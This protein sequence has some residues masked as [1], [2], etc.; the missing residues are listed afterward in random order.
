[1]MHVLEQFSKLFDKKQKRS[2]IF[3][4]MLMVLGAF[5][6]T[7]GI[8]LIVPLVAVVLDEKFFQ[9]NTVVKNISALLGIESVKVFVIYML[10][11]LILIFII[12]DLFLFFEYYI[13]QKFVCS[14]RVRVQKQLMESFLQRPYEFFLNESTGNIQRS[15][16]DDVNRSFM[17]LNNVMTLFTEL[18]VCIAVLCAVIAVDTV[19]AIFV[20]IVLLAEVLLILTK[21]KPAMTRLGN[22]VREVSA[23]INKWI[24]QSVQGIKEIKVT[25][26]QG[27][28]VQ[29]YENHATKYAQMER[30]N[31]LINNAPRLII[32]A[33][34]I[35]AMLGLMV[36]LLLAGY[37][38]ENLLPQLSAFAVAAVRLLPSANRISGSM[39]NLS[40]WK[41]NLD[42]LVENMGKLEEWERKEGDLHVSG[43]AGKLSLKESCELSD[44]TYSYSEAEH[45]VLDHANML[46]PVGK[47]IGIVGTSGAGKTTA[48]DILL[49]L[50]SPQGGRVLSDGKSI[51]DD[52]D[53][54]LQQLSYIPQSIFLL[55]D[56]IAANVAFGHD[57]ENIDEE[58]VRSALRE[59]QLEEFIQSL[60]EGIFTKIGE[61]GIR[62]SGGQRQR[63]GIARALYGNPELLV[64]DEATSALDNET[65][66]AIME[67]I[68]AL[69]GKKTLIIIAHRL[70]TIQ[71]CDIVYRVDNK[72]IERER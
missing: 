10:V 24:I 47:S 19:M 41:P 1:M 3:I 4:V 57:M 72:K 22:N 12:K 6:E 40:L 31:Q 49:G 35:S 42:A 37:S 39:N 66:A 11:L 30:K 14:S 27:F 55:D 68:N 69:H 60:P 2:V 18:I 53:W 23:Q 63:I 45:N 34:T 25:G 43:Q 38:M 71:G 9:T 16:I 58:Q 46:I 26:K 61:R 64:F 5:F 59:A 29:N 20:C 50:L 44:I 15:V 52:Y 67:S 54:W 21:V 8:S 32:E 13:Q 48:I 33:V 70:T 62:L 17:L 28:F 51:M 56:T 7:F 36:L 65:E